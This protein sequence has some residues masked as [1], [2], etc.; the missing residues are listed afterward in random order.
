MTTN[1]RP[2]AGTLC[3]HFGVTKPQADNNDDG[4]DRVIVTFH[5]VASIV[6][7]DRFTAKFHPSYLDFWGANIFSLLYDNV[8]RFFVLP[9]NASQMFLIVSLHHPLRRKRA[10]Y[11]HFVLQFNTHNVVDMSL[12][13]N[14]DSLN[15][16]YKGRL[17][18]SYQGLEH[19]IFQ[20]IF[21]GLSGAQV[22]KPGKFRSKNDHYAVRSTFQGVNGLLYPLE[23]C[24]F[25]APKPPVLIEHQEV[26]FVEFENH[27]PD[28]FSMRLR[29]DTPGV[30]A[31][32]VFQ[33]INF[34]EFS[35]L[36]EY[37]RENSLTVAFKTINHVEELGNS[38]RIEGNSEDKDAP[39]DDGPSSDGDGSMDDAPS[40]DEDIHS[41]DGD[42]FDPANEIWKGFSSYLYDD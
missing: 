24:F 41:S 20:E 34:N 23:D 5:N 35:S 42:G 14:E 2:L 11:P 13:I 38:L 10:F 29:M 36:Y 7:R 25:F 28:S 18:L 15:T 8:R 22:E 39:M 30:L 27:G 9:K 12:S 19:V 17:S 21:S 4:D 37:M 32:Y 26:E 33:N 16:K 31:E 40:S 6:S 3:R 1:P